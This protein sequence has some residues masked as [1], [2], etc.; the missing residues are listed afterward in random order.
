MRWAADETPAVEDDTPGDPVLVHALRL[1]LKSRLPAPA[2]RRVLE[3]ALWR[4]GSHPNLAR[5]ETEATLLRDLLLSGS[6]QVSA[7]LGVDPRNRYLPAGIPR[8]DHAFFDIAYQY[9]QFVAIPRKI[10]SAHRLR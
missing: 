5:L 1:A 10:P 4:S 3:E 7:K 8:S 2:A 9:Q 6:I